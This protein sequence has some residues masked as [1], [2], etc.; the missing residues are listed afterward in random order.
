M[1]FGP[2][3]LVLLSHVDFSFPLGNT[4]E[5]CMSWWAGL[6]EKLLFLVNTFIVI[7]TLWYQMR[8]QYLNAY[9]REAGD[10]VTT[11]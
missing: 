9:K 11:P 6:Q 5:R 3:V 4:Y 2:A 7:W 8:W 10:D 1:Y